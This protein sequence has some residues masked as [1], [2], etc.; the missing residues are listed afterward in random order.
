MRQLFTTAVLLLAVP[1]AAPNADAQT[2]DDT[3]RLKAEI[4]SLRKQVSNL[5]K[6]NDL[7]KRE[8]E[9][10]KRE[11]KSK[12]DK[13]GAP[14]TDAKPRT[15]ATEQ[16]GGGYVVDWELLECVRDPKKPT[17]VSFTF[18]ARFDKERMENK[19]KLSRVD[20]VGVC[21]KVT[22][23]NSD[24]KELDGKVADG[25]TSVVALS[26]GERSKFQVTFEG[27][28]AEITEFDEVGLAMGG[29]LGFPR[30]PV[31]FYRIK[32]ESK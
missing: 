26:E 8:I 9:L 32:I 27:V 1:G 5:E 17:R 28:D 4:E 16:V 11:A 24:G 30:L 22:L 21:K 31:K 20:N 29:P 18:A 19:G 25:P 12:P 2:T 3:A 6:E 13:V 14:G 7:L 23:T 15:T 10:M